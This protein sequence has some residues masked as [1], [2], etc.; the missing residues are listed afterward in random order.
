L[1]SG[2]TAGT[3][4]SL[5]D[6]VARFGRMPQARRRSRGGDPE[7]IE[8][9][10]RS[11]LRGRGGAGFPTA[12]KLAAVAGAARGHPVVVANGTEG[13][14]AS[15]KDKLLLAGAPHLVLDGAVLAARAVGAREAI[16]CVDREARRY[17]SN[18]ETA[19][20]ERSGPAKGVSIRILAVPSRYTSGEESALVRRLNGGDAR[21]TFGAPRPYERG[22][23][24]RPTLVQNVETLAHLALIARF[25]DS[26]F[27]EIGTSA[28][29]G[30]VLVTVRGA[31]RPAAICEM[32]VG[33][34]LREVLAT[35]GITEPGACLVGGY[36][37][38][39]LSPST[40]DVALLSHESLGALGASL[41]AGVV[42]AVGPQGC[43]LIET[44]RVLRYLAGETAQQCGPCIFGLAA[45]ADGLDRLVAGGS[46]QSTV[47]LRRWIAQVRGRGACRHPDGAVALV[48]S[49]LDVF[50]AEIE[51]HGLHGPCFA[52]SRPGVLPIP[53]LPP[54]AHRAWR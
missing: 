52:S 18:L 44:A 36:F 26:W 39:W 11:G 50:G 3:M 43:G 14:P 24:G 51:R 34:P 42:G 21:P 30:S 32:A 46:D 7:L 4:T 19:L 25:G 41:G 8:L 17:W 23:D 16:V 20:G 54:T 6:H 1:L 15:G 2:L 27:R 35:V 29:P 45:I 28:E 31:A 48:E 22:V 12:K 33:T 38:R 13:E 47:T 37:G 53:P 9:V 40:V 10:A 5:A 49:A